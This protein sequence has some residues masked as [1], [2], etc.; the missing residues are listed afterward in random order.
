[1]QIAF[2]KISLLIAIILLIGFFYALI[3]WI[4]LG[5]KR[6][7]ILPGMGV[8]KCS[9]G[10]PEDT[11]TRV[12]KGERAHTKMLLKYGKP[13]KM[14]EIQT[15]SVSGLREGIE[16]SLDYKQLGIHFTFYRDRLKQITV[17]QRQ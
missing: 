2:S 3:R 12:F 17:N 13:D 14:S 9:I 11:F 15:Y 6:Y 4:L 7:V 10:M 8:K 1:M 5:R 16:K